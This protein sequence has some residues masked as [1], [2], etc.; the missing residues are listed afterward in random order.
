[1]KREIGEIFEFQGRLYETVEDNSD[2][3]LQC[4]FHKEK[5]CSGNRDIIGSCARF[6]RND[7][8][9]VIFK[10]VNKLHGITSSATSNKKKLLL[11][12]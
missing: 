12:I 9:T 8:T 3:C 4:V 1:M 2:S 11:I 7:G 6:N 5:E 10:A